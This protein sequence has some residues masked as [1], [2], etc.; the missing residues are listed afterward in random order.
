MNR[1]TNQIAL[2][3]DVL[4][5]SGGD[6]SVG[7]SHDS[8]CSVLIESIAYVYA[9]LPNQKNTSVVKDVHLPVI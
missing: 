3:S 2:D 6:G 8:H 1:S 4:T 9:S 5:R 7:I